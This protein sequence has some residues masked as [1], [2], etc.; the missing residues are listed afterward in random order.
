[1]A[2]VF[3]INGI[4]AE[5][6]IG[7]R[8]YKFRDPRFQEKVLLK[9]EWDDVLKDDLLADKP[10]TVARIHELN[11]KQVKLYLPDFDDKHLEELGDT[12]VNL[13][14]KAIQEAAK[15]NFG[16]YMESAEKK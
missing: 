11:K 13:V 6:K 15:H 12:E 7:G 1:M 5:L 4:D 8:K 3:E 16:A 9:K 10:E 14:L 2:H